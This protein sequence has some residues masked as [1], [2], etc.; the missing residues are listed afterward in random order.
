MRFS[1]GIPMPGP[2]RASQSLGGRTNSR[3]GYFAQFQ[4]CTVNH[5]DHDAERRCGRRHPEAAPAAVAPRPWWWSVDGCYCGAPATYAY[6]VEGT[7]YPTKDLLVMNG[8]PCVFRCSRHPD[9]GRCHNL[10]DVPD[11]RVGS[12]R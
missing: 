12:D 8:N 10:L 3:P 4:S 11:P 1:I 9:S 6:E 5:R 7:A 2:I